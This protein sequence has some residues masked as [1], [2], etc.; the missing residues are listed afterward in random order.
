MGKANLPYFGWVGTLVGKARTLVGKANL[1]YFGWVGSLLDK[2][3]TLVGKA[4]TLVGKVN[5]PYFGWVGTLVGKARTLVGKARTLVGKAIFA[6]LRL[7][8]DLSGQGKAMYS[9]VELRAV[10]SYLIAGVAIMKRCRTP[11]NPRG[12]VQLG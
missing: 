4:R 11:R 10:S 2:A 3:R 9:W 8:R 5:L 6:L 7:G 1:P 12:D